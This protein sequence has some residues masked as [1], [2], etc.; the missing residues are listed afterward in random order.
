MFVPEYDPNKVC[1]AH[2]NKFE[3]NVN[4]IYAESTN[5][6]I[7]HT[8]E[9][10]TSRKVVLYRPTVSTNNAVGCDCK[11]FYIGKND[12][13]LRVSGT[14]TKIGGKE[15]TLHF[16][17]YEFYFKYLMQLV[18]GGETLTAFIKSEKMMSTIFFGHDK[19]PEYKMIL[20]KGWEIFCHALRFPEDANYCYEC[21]QELGAGEHE[22]D[23][24]PS[25]PG[26]LKLQEHPGV[27]KNLSTPLKS[28]FFQIFF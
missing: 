14:K 28:N 4:I 7:H 2:N 25:S 23:F 26:L 15:R 3:E 18:S 8:R 6:L 22:D 21:P 13:L 9:V 16:V 27:G 12:Q 5:I 19:S 10:N 24:N 1:E 17:S 11:D 20:Q